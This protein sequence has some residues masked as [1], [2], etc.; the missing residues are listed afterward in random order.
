MYDE[1]VAQLE[2]ACERIWQDGRMGCETLSLTG[3]TCK[4]PRHKT[5]SDSE[6]D[7]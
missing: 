5:P 3:N 7:R 6:D 1:Y 2:E 4:H